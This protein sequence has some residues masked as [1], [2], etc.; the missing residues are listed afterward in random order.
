MKKWMLWVIALAAL[1]GSNLLAQSITGTWQGTAQVNGTSYRAVV[2]ISTSDADTLKGVMYPS[3]D[4][5]GQSLPL[6]VVS[7]QSSAVKFTVPGIGGNYEGKLSAEGNTMAGTWSIGETHVAL[8]LTR[9]T[10][11]SAWTIPE[12]PPPPV[13]MAAKMCIRD[14]N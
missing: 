10:P 4:Q 9:A 7:V 6:G 11:E 2:K 13:R 12:P 14:R 5:S 1:S 3:I 8:N